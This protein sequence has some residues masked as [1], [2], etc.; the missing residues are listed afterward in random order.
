MENFHFNPF[1][2]IW[3]CLKIVDLIF[4]HQDD[5]FYNGEKTE[6]TYGFIEIR[7]RKAAPKNRSRRQLRCPSFDS[8]R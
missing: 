4:F 7:G 5:I 3:V 6:N 1:Q 2:A 8:K